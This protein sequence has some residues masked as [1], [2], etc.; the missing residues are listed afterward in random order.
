MHET[1]FGFLSIFFPLYVIIIGGSP[2]DLGIMSMSALL[3]AILFSFFWG[4]LCD[5]LKRYKLFILLSFLS[6]SIILYLFTFIRSITLFTIL[7]VLLSVFHIAH[8]AP[9]NVMISE[10]YTYE[11]WVEAFAFYEAFTEIGWTV[12]LLLGFL[13]SIYGFN[14]ENMLLV[15]S[16][17][18]LSAFATSIFFV[19]D[20]HILIERGLVRIERFISFVCRGVT[21]LTKSLYGIPVS[22]KL[23]RENIYGFCVG[24]T[25]FMFATSVLFTPLPIIFSRNLFASVSGVF[26]IFILNSLGGVVGYLMAWI[27]SQWTIGENRMGGIVAFRSALTLLMILAIRVPAYNITFVTLILTLMGFA[28]A[29]FYVYTLSTSMG[30]LSEGE[31]GLFNTV[32]GI[33]NAL[34]SFIGPYLAKTLE[35]TYV[36]LASGII[37]LASSIIL[38]LST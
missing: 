19:N 14:A 2:I 33:G 37:F 35:F 6:I 9:K 20:P 38:K 34:G 4:Y 8:E 32:I 24:L 27:K 21:V 7:Y 10:T 13:A 16:L 1:A 22:G 15:C 11:E 25:L 28:Y 12:G 30:L 29:V 3:S 31:A 26:A 5:K 23:R 36:L 18:N 17:L